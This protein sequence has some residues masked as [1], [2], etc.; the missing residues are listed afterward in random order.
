MG[1]KAQAPSDAPVIVV[2]L[3]RFGA[4]TAASLIR[5]GHEV[6]AV[7]ED[8][9][10]VQKWASELTHAVQVD[11]TD[12]EALRQ[13]GADQ[14]ERAIVGIGSDIEASVLTVLT[15]VELGVS[16]VWAKAVSI[17]HGKIL[18]RVGAS[19]VVYPERAMGERVA[20]MV[21]GQ[22]IDYM[23]FDDG[24]AI[25]RTRAPE[26]AYDKTLTESA[27]RSRY[28][29]TVVGIKRPAQ[30]FTYAQADTMIRQRDELI[31]SGS[32][33]KVEKFCAVTVAS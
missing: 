27:L 28:G 26:E 32:T 21:S 31:V 17:K 3:G 6:L 20:H 7:D 23:E 16:E 30:D 18:K 14:F 33:H 24:F 22:M 25:A 9:E 8:A 13:I 4:A 1:K 19:H 29:V 10:L 12:E 15:L 2:G 5:L 11:T